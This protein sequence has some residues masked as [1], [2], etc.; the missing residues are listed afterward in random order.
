MKTWTKVKLGI[1][2]VSLAGFL[3]L[4]TDRTETYRKLEEFPNLNTNLNA[5]V[6]YHE[7]ENELDKPI[8]I[9][10]ALNQKN[11]KIYSD[12]KIEK[13]SLDS[14]EGFYNLKQE[15]DRLTDNLI[16]DYGLL[17]LF[18]IP[19]ALSGGFLVGELINSYSRKKSKKQ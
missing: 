10:D 9:K 3:W 1:A 7:I 19:L 16:N 2:G 17:T 8:R 18:G 11:L 12:L 13:D 4:L 14:I 6:R 15:Y 5:I